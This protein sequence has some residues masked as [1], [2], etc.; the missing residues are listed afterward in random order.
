MA[1]LITTLI[2]GFGIM[3]A[4]LKKIWALLQGYSQQ[5]E[6]LE[7][8]VKKLEAE[9]CQMAADVKEILKLLTEP[10]VTGI[11]VVHEPPAP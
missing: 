9:H 4:L 10:E 7:A 11:E 6:C 5:F 3:I 1:A 2:L 8:Q